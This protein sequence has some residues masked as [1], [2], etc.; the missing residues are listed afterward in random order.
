M[1][2][3]SLKRFRHTGSVRDYVKEFS[4]LMLDIKNMLEEDK[5]FNFMSGLQGW[6]Q[7]K[8]HRQ[9]VCDL[10]TAMIEADSLVDYKMGGAISTMQKPKSEGGK[11]AKAE[12]KTFK[13][14]RWKKQN[15]KSVIGVKPMEKTIKLVQQSTQMAGCFICNGPHQARDCPKREKF[16]TLVFADN[17]GESDSKTPPRVN[18]LQLLD[19][20]HG[21]TPV[22]KSLMHVPV[23]LNGVQVKTIM[24]SGVTHNFMATKEATRLGLKLKE[25]TILFKAVN[26]K[27]AKNVPMQV[28]DWKGTCSLLCVSLDDFNFIL[29]VNFLLKAKVALIPHLG[30]LVVLE[31]RQSCFV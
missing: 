2:S 13:K 14:S 27:I 22:Q 28:G 11:K 21:E 25:D 12:G 20:L 18:P 30:G 10:P 23:I 26:R 16:S 6:A 1:A 29:G 9:G 4:S 31:E 19:V 5:F 3:E 8:L 17:E 15:K 7:T 24:D